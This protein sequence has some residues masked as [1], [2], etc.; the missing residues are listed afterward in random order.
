M[1]VKNTIIK[2]NAELKQNNHWRAKEIIRGSIGNLKF[3]PELYEYYGQI[4][5]STNDIMEAGKFLFLAGTV[6][7]KYSNAIELFKS[8]YIKKDPTFIYSIFPVRA[9]LNNLSEYPESIQPLLREIGFPEVLNQ[10]N[11]YINCSERKKIR[12]LHRHNTVGKTSVIGTIVGLS[13]LLIILTLLILGI[14]KF[15]DIIF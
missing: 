9:K 8:R 4:L 15:I 2:A 11:G 3:D 6:N 7:P 12:S 1:S 13:V 14:L 5:L 10:K